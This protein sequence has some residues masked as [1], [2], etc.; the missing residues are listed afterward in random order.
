MREV[1]I[2][3]TGENTTLKKRLHEL[4]KGTKVLKFLVGFFY[5][6]GIRELF[7]PLQENLLNNE[8]NILKILVGM[9]IDRLNHQI[10]EISHDQNNSTTNSIIDN[11]LS[12][13]RESLK[14]DNLDTKEFNDQFSF[15][16]DMIRKD[17]IQIRKTRMPNHAKLYIAIDKDNKMREKTFI[18]GSSN[19]T[20][21]GLST[22]AEFNVELSDY[23]VG[24]IAEEFFDKLWEDS[25]KITEFEDVK[26][27]L[28]NI[29]EKET[30]T[31][32][33]TPFEA[34]V[35]ALRSYLDVSSPKGK[36]SNST[37]S[38]FSKNGYKE[39]DYQIDAIKQALNIIDQYNGV[40]IADVVGLGK[41]VIASAVGREIG[42]RGVILCPPGL[43]GDRGQ[44]SGWSMYKRQFGLHDWEIRS[45]GD[46]EDTA[47]FLQDHGDEFKIIILDEAHRFR[48]PDTQSYEHLKNICRNRKVMLL[49]ATPFNNNP[50]D[51]IALLNLFIIPKK[52]MITLDD[53][54]SARFRTYRIEFDHLSYITRYHNSPE[55]Q[56]R[57]NALERYQKVF[58]KAE[59]E[60]D[61]NRVNKRSKQLSQEIREVITPVLIRRNRLDLLSN[62]AYK[63]EISTLSKIDDPKEWFYELSKEQSEL[64]DRIIKTYFN[65][66]LGSIGQ[67]NLGTSFTGAIYQ[68]FRYEKIEKS[69]EEDNFES[70]QQ[71]QLAGF[72]RR[73]MVKRFESSFGSFQASIKNLLAITEKVLDF[74]NRTDKYILDRDLLNK[75]YDLDDDEI[76]LE[77]DNYAEKLV[78]SKLS[79]KNKVYR[80]SHFER[81][82][83]FINDIESDINLFNKI[84]DELDQMNLVEDDPKSKQLIKSI[85]K[86]LEEDPKRK[87]II[88]TEYADTVAHLKLAM[89]ARFGKRMLIV[90]GRLSPTILDDIYENFDAS[91]DIQKNEYDILLSTDRIS[92]G[93]NLNRAGLIVNYDIP[94]NPVRVIQRVGRINR[95]S[96][97]V[98]EHLHI[99][100]FFPTERGAEIVKMREIAAAKMFAIHTILGEDSKI[101]NIDEEPSPSNLYTRLSSNIDEIEGVSF[102]T[103]MVQRWTKIA[104]QHPKLAEEINNFPKKVKVSKSG[105]ENELFV[106]FRK[107]GFF[108]QHLLEGESEPTSLTFEEAL[109]AIECQNDEPRLNFS[110]RFWES[111][112]IAK[113][114]KAYKDLIP[115]KEESIEGQA[116][117]NLETLLSNC[118]NELITY[119]PFIKELLKDV[120]EFGTLPVFTLRTISQLKFSNSREILEARTKIQTL[121]LQL[122]KGYLEKE[123]ERIQNY[124]QEII[125]A[126]ENQK[127]EQN[128]N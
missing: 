114:I 3:N 46:L 60:I 112:Q 62:P 102:Y 24:D 61:I 126:I 68:P 108:V 82:K 47:K 72:M 39:Y 69:G 94:W 63:K 99:V 56:K 18:T 27:R 76:N 35:L 127:N 33:I 40:I 51:I 36:L 20:K 77:L 116:L 10:I 113:S 19:L 6:S 42:G 11:Y 58:G 95:I 128:N 83:T 37:L 48:N 90:D 88:F 84:L 87:I 110:E 55:V 50:S 122:G 4:V 125:I 81:R 96:K 26:A 118:P 78:N 79:K 121:Q 12:N 45:V 89:H 66:E 85:E 64:Y 44:N 109:R 73:L 1:F 29:L 75:I 38:A 5:F 54:L 41:S 59:T 86:S 32:Q 123:D 52:S 119:Q 103:E 100:N 80:V 74:I 57:K 13:V 53:D 30:H 14:D 101:F 98:F 17:Q 106:F 67:K 117:N 65:P 25:V 115:I 97:K 124:T 9:S 43:M 92:E 16:I 120:R 31:R 70:I 91:H 15:F 93:F 22:Q 71:E 21:A 34:Y 28:I 111:Y 105:F 8:D 7:A 2:S 23:G 104:E 107:G 49:T